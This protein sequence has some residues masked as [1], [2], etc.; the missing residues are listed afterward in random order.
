MTQLTRKNIL[1]PTGRYVQGNVYEGKT[2]D[3]KGE[4]LVYKTGKNKGQPRIEWYFAVAI[5]K[6][7]GLNWWDEPWGQEIVRVANACFPGGQT[8]RRDFSWK[9]KDGD[10][11]EPNANMKR[12]CDREGWPGHWIVGVNS[13]FLPRIVNQDGTGPW[14]GPG[15]LK[16]G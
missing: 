14:G 8:T 16:L 2:H 11:T 4:L 1:L 10:S 7:P 12:N 5:A 3:E 13:G 9:V 6:T 15:D